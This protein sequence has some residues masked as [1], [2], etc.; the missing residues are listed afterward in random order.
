M[1]ERYSR[2]QR[3]ADRKRLKVKRQFHWGYGHKDEWACRQP[4][5]AGTI[6]YM[7]PQTAGI[8][9]NT[10]SPCSCWMCGNARR[11]LANGSPLTRQ[12]RRAYDSYV[13]QM[14]ELEGLHD[15]EIYYG[16]SWYEDDEWY[17]QDSATVERLRWKYCN[18]YSDEE[19][20]WQ[21][22][23]EVHDG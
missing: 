5:E 16:A 13:T 9:V 1:T 7:S 10:P 4:A 23:K 3:K 17:F 21:I 20:M 19:Y 18:R 14:E 15:E 2:A 11:T 8:V 22:L 6:N 12:E